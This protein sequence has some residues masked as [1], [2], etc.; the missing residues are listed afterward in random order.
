MVSS[1]YAVLGWRVGATG[2]AWASRRSSGPCGLNYSRAMDS[3]IRRFAVEPVDEK[4]ARTSAREIRLP[5]FT[6]ASPVILLYKSANVLSRRERAAGEG[7]PDRGA[8]I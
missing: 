8:A 2:V 4:R 5:A 3:A 1:V 6:M 7:G